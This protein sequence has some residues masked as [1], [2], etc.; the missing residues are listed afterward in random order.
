MPIQNHFAALQKTHLDTFFGLSRQIVDGVDE[1]VRLN[2][3]TTRSTMADTL[4]GALR[5]LPP[6]EPREWF[7]RQNA[8]TTRASEKAQAYGRQLFEIVV[9]TQTE[10]ARTLREQWTAFG[11]ETK[12]LADNVANGAPT[13]TATAMGAFESAFAVANALVETFQASGART[14]EIARGHL[15]TAAAL[16]AAPSAEPTAAQAQAAK[17]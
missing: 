4:D 11:E 2:M 1:L 8:R 9:T 10:C 12:A 5:A 13:G 7:E 15:D 14:L 17:R 6:V 16:A 3:Q